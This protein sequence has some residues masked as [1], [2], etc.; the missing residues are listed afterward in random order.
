MEANATHIVGGVI[1]Y[2]YLGG[3]KYKIIFEIYKDCGPEVEI[4]FDGSCSG[5]NCRLP[6]FYISLF[7][8]N[9]NTNILNNGSRRNELLLLDTLI[10]RPVI[11]NPCLKINNTCVVRGRYETIIDLPKNDIGYTIQ[12]Q[13]CCRNNGII[14]INNQP[15]TSDKPGITL[16]TY[17]P[18]L[19]TFK[20]NSARFKEF[21]PIFI[22]VGQQFYFDHS[23][24]DAD[25]DVLEYSLIDP[26]TGLSSSQPV[27]EYQYLNPAPI[28]WTSPYNL[29]DVIGGSP[30]MKIDT[31]SG[32]LVCKPNTVGRFVVSIMVKERRGGV[33][34]D[35]FARDFQYNVV[36]CDIPNANAPFIDG[37]Y[38]PAKNIGDYVQ[39]GNLKVNFI[40]TSTNATRYEWYFGDPNSGTNN[41][42]TNT[43]PTH[44]FSDTGTFI[45]VLKAFKT[46]ST[47][48]LC[49]DST[50]RICRI[51]PKPKV[52]FSFNDPCQG[53]QVQFTDLTTTS[54]G[55]VAS[56]K[57]EFGNGNSSTQ[58]NP[59][60]IYANPGRYNV[61]L[62]ALNAKQC[63]AD[64]TI[65]I[66]VH[67]KPTINA[68]IPPACIGQALNLTC[69]ITIPAP[70]TIVEYKWTLPDGNIINTCNAS[71]IP[72]ALGS[73]SVNLWAKSDK[74]C[75]NFT[76]FPYTVNPLPTI[77]SA[78]DITLCYD[79]TARLGANGGVSY[80]WS[81]TTYLSDPNIVN[82]LAS[83]PYPNSILYTVEGTNANGC[84]NTD[85]MRIR[86]HTKTPID[87]GMD[88][89]VCLNNSPFKYRD[90]VRLNGIGTFTS[91]YWL[92]VGGLNN[93]NIANP[94]AK[95]K[96]NT[97]YI[98]H[99]IDLNNCLIK[100]TVRV[101]VL[102]PNIDLIDK[103]DS[104]LCLG[105]TIR[106]LPYDQGKITKYS[107]TPNIW[108]SDPNIRTPQAY[109]LD[110]IRYILFVE[111]YCYTKFDSILLNVN[112][113]ADL[114]LPALDSICIGDLYRFNANSSFKTYNWLLADAT[115]SSR[116]IF[117]PTASPKLTQKYVL[118]A[119]D[120][121]DCEMKDSMLLEVNLPPTLSLLGIPNY[122][123]QGDSALIISKSDQQSKITWRDK[124]TLSSD[125]GKR[126]YAFPRD[127]TRYFLTATTI[128]NCSTTTSF[129]VNVQKPI[130]PWA[131]RPVQVCKGKPIDLKAEGGLYYR[132]T[133]NNNINDTLSSKP[134]VFPDQT[135]TYKVY[136]SNDC[137]IDSLLVDV[138]VDSLP[139]V[140]AG[141]DTTIYRG[142]EIALFAESKGELYNWKP[143]ALVIDNPF[144]STIHVAP[145]DTTLFTVE[146][147]NGRGCIGFD[148]VWVNVYGKNVLLVPTGFSPNGDG[149]NDVFKIVKYLNIRE[150]RYFEVYNRWGEKVFSTQNINAGWDGIYKGAQAPASVYV[151][152]IEAVNFD[153]E[154]ITQSGNVT[155]LR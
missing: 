96:L 30:A 25:G 132:W 113:P 39:C 86:F 120:R 147:T 89:S 98:F 27:D 49:Q 112:V 36:D 54:F 138:Y 77:V 146:V 2:E 145:M 19:N 139:N 94:Q 100:D 46:K 47:G 22:C 87:A 79:Q 90:S 133:P 32:L 35:S 73:G 68:T 7:E 17:I 44:T 123:C 85:T 8:G 128:K 65:S 60:I 42:S 63:P 13:R 55:N 117:N 122:I 144:S 48:Q 154:K 52:N 82:P 106:L 129:I 84:S 110:T 151:W 97:D 10:I 20:N 56:W 53:A 12:H 137:F 150:L 111:N 155:L 57:W 78:P 5:P 9:T 125:T 121:Y 69:N 134:Q 114:G 141:K 101:I 108:L 99:G 116:T 31:H 95:P 130:V 28:V 76:D 131:K 37:T 24:T 142:Q 135:S 6:P 109:P 71:F 148:S 92:P 58:K 104:F 50:R 83:P 70:S 118:Q 140:N 80:T 149:V 152:K 59:K 91:V 16:R 67:P 62:T 3:T 1:Y 143:K 61:K 126:V 75:E 43:N 23:A 38:D 88:T 26:L 153:N 15:T 18:P 51:Y 119:K 45:V 107:W 14:N 136:I 102:D 72:S 21:P 74:G 33:I 29:N 105:D 81:P 40:N 64:T 66:T 93:P 11:V 127:T 4:G 34:V 103:K 41:F 124:S 115:I